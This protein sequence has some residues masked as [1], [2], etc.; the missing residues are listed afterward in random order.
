MLDSAI[1]H[2]R[3][4]EQNIES[5]NTRN[6]I[7]ALDS[8]DTFL[9]GIKAPYDKGA[10]LRTG[11]SRR[12]LKSL[13]AR[14]GMPKRRLGLFATWRLSALNIHTTQIGSVTQ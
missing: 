6:A 12:Q 11:L 1:G 8:V 4:A 3:I 7:G 13:R 10:S 5:G 14:S 9:L 2:L